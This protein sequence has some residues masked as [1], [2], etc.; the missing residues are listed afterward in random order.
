MRAKEVEEELIH[1]DVIEGNLSMHVID[2][3]GKKAK[4][5]C[6]SI[7]SLVLAKINLKKKG[8]TRTAHSL[9]QYM[10][11]FFNFY[12]ILKNS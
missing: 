10:F 9:I 6:A 7:E 8:K 2:F 11:F 3:N 12:F 5:L 1:I 4:R